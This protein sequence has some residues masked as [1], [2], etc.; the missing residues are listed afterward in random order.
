MGGVSR[1]P[2]LG[3]PLPGGRV[4]VAASGS[5]PGCE[6]AGLGEGAPGIV[7]LL[8]ALCATSPRAAPCAVTPPTSTGTPQGLGQGECPK[9]RRAEAVG[10]PGVSTPRFCPCLPEMPPGLLWAFLSSKAGGSRKLQHSTQAGQTKAW[11]STDSWLSEAKCSG[12]AEH[13]GGAGR[14]SP[15]TCW[16]E[17]TG[18]LRKGKPAAGSLPSRV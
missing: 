3:E 1:R 4:L 10:L 6:A 18:S 17:A 7:S 12:T 13:Q 8:C 5:G 15:P 9:V 11:G 16:A 14:G 2:P